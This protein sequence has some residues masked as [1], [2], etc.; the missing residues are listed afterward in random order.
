MKDPATKHCQIPPQAKE[1]DAKPK[2]KR[3]GTKKPPVSFE[4]FA[5]TV[6]NKEDQAAG[7]LTR[8]K[9]TAQRLSGAFHE[10]WPRDRSQQEEKE[11]ESRHPSATLTPS[12]TRFAE[13]DAEEA[14]VDPPQKEKGMGRAISMKLPLRSK[15]V[16]QSKASE[17]EQRDQ[18]AEVS[19]SKPANT[20]QATKLKGLGRALSLRSSSLITGDASRT[21]SKPVPR[22]RA[23]RRTDIPAIVEEPA[24][25]N[26]TEQE[27]KGHDRRASL[28]VRRQGAKSAL[29]IR[30]TPV[31]E[32]EV[33][34]KQSETSKK[35]EKPSTSKW[36]FWKA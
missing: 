27:K 29:S 21:S 31:Q 16:K 8:S 15:S 23:S 33:V 28:K 34:A 19:T 30:A 4:K 20:T 2:P 1:P 9:S 18:S 17:A 32:A 13:A 25:S 35:Q 14:T 11:Q 12:K 36:K 3:R 24:S 10:I 7:A 5:S 26:G 22:G 6:A